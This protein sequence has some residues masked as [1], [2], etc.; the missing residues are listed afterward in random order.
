MFAA[1]LNNQYFHNI[2]FPTIVQHG[3]TNTNA[4]FQLARGPDVP[5]LL[6]KEVSAIILFIYNIRLNLWEIIILFIF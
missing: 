1:L 4:D 3:Y 6:R 5:E 2:H